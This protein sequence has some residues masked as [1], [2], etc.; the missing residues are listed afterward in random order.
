[1]QVTFYAKCCMMSRVVI[2]ARMVM[3]VMV[4]SSMTHYRLY[5]MVLTE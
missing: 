5:P 3:T 1:M 2:L 4:Q